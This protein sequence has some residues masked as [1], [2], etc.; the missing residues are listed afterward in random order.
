[1]TVFVIGTGIRFSHRDFGG[2]AVPGFDYE[3]GSGDD[4]NGHRTH[5]AGTIGGASYGVAKRVKL[6]AVRVLGCQGSGSNADVMAGID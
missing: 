1:V 6:V 4:C 5:V 2:R 3:G